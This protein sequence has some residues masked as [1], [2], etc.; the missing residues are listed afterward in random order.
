MCEQNLKN[1]S[2][3]E[4][5]NAARKCKSNHE[6]D[7]ISSDQRMNCIQDKGKMSSLFE[8]AFKII[9]TLLV[10]EKLEVDREL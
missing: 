9:L 7:A 8:E 4:S 5:Q 10:E 2:G 1:T 3:T 6:E